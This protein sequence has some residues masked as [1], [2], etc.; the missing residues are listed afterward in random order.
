VYAAALPRSMPAGG[1]AVVEPDRLEH[2]KPVAAVSVAKPDRQV[3]VDEL[4]A[5]IG[6]E[7]RPMD[8]ARAVL[9]ATTGR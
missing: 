8:Q 7:R 5:T 9:L 1:A 3:I 2:G 6:E 4:A